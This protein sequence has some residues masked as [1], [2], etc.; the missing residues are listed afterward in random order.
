MILE[1]KDVIHL[2]IYAVSIAAVL[3][4]Y[5]NRISHLEKTIDR[6][7][8]VLFTDSGALNFVSQENCKGRQDHVYTAIRRGESTQEQTLKKIDQLNDNIL[9]ILF[10]LKIEKKSESE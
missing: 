6:I 1:I 7:N 2:I 4:T 10:Y 5:R 3:I 8:K 9:K